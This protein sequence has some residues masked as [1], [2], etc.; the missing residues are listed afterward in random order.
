VAEAQQ[1]RF[2]PIS[3]WNDKTLDRIAAKLTAF[4]PA[5]LSS[6]GKL[7]LWSSLWPFGIILAC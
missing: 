7:S 3:Q 4:A 6:S 2:I 5:K 1:G